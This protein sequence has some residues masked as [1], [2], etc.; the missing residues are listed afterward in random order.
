M[1]CFVGLNEEGKSAI[2][3]ALKFI[4]TGTCSKDSSV[5]DLV[6]EGENNMGGELTATDNGK[7]YIIARRKLP[8]IVD[9]SVSE[10]IGDKTE[11]V[12]LSKSGLQKRIYDM[13]GGDARSVGLLFDSFSFLGLEEGLQKQILY[14]VCVGTQLDV[15]K[16]LQEFLTQEEI[17]YILAIDPQISN[18]D[19]I[20]NTIQLRRR[21]A[22]KMIPEKLVISSDIKLDE[23]AA[24]RKNLDTLLNEK[25]VFDEIR[26]RK[27]KKGQFTNEKEALEKKLNEKPGP[28]KLGEEIHKIE[29]EIKTISVEDITQLKAQFE[30]AQKRLKSAQEIEGTCPLYNCECPLPQEKREKMVIGFETAVR[31]LGTK[32][33]HNIDRQFKLDELNQK[34]NELDAQIAAALGETETHQK[35][36]EQINREL[37]QIGDTVVPD[38]DIDSEITTVTD[39]LSKIELLKQQKK[40]LDEYDKKRVEMKTKDAMMTKIIEVLSPKTGL[41]D[42]MISAYISDFNNLVNTMAPHILNGRTVG[43]DNN[44]NVWLDGK[45]VKSFL[46]SSAKMRVGISIQHAIA[47]QLKADILVID[48]LEQLDKGNRGIVLGTLLKG[49]QNGSVIL[50]CAGEKP[51]PSSTPGVALYNIEKHTVSPV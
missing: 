37:E 16:A 47:K 27:V 30:S 12:N 44:L 5:E 23:E 7:T 33:N 34:K 40:Q 18:F 25:Q 14:N 36:L 15:K 41:R 17:D 31:E 35:R 50:T 9:L 39:K 4:L 24:L 26:A 42:K 3:E 13:L 32:L 19:K 22:R 2:C 51:Q 1:T 45:K 43:I 6:K 11:K 48:N 28:F 38:K 8:S 49:Y 21:E 46:S 29:E 10:V 20:S